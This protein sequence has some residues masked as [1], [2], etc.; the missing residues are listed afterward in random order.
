M[1]GKSLEELIS[2]LEHD[3][4][5][6]PSA[7]E[8]LDSC[9][10]VT[11][12]LDRA[13][14]PGTRREQLLDSNSS[15]SCDL[16]S[17]AEKLKRTMAPMAALVR[18]CQAILNRVQTE[19]PP[20]KEKHRVEHRDEDEA[21]PSSDRFAHGVKDKLSNLATS[22][23]RDAAPLLRAVLELSNAV[24]D[25]IKAYIV[26]PPAS[27]VW[28]E[29]EVAM[30]RRQVLLSMNVDA[31]SSASRLLP[32]VSDN[33]RSICNVL[34]PSRLQ[35][36]PELF[37]APADIDKVMT[38]FGDVSMDTNE[39]MK[40]AVKSA[41]EAAAHAAA[42][43]LDRLKPTLYQEDAI[44]VPWPT[45]G[46]YRRDSAE[47]EEAVRRFDCVRLASGSDWKDE[48][49]RQAFVDD[50]QML[51][52]TEQATKIGNMIK[53]EPQLTL[54]FGESGAGK[55]MAVVAAARCLTTQGGPRRYPVVWRA[56]V[57]DIAGTKDDAAQDLEME[58]SQY[59]NTDAK[60]A[61]EHRV[62]TLVKA[63]LDKN[64][65]KKTGLHNDG[66][67]LVLF[68]DE[69]GAYPNFVRA[70]VA[71]V[72][73]GLLNEQDGRPKHTSLG[74]FGDQTQNVEVR[75]VVAGTGVEGPTLR[76]GSSIDRYTLVSMP[77][78]VIVRVDAPVKE[79]GAAS[80]TPVPTKR[81]EILLELF[82]DEKDRDFWTHIFD[83]ATPST[84]K[85]PEEWEAHH[86][87][88]NPRA[89]VQ[90][91]L[92]Y[93]QW[94][95]RVPLESHAPTGFALRA[96]TTMAAIQFKKLNGLKNLLLPQYTWAM[97]SALSLAHDSPVARKTIE[98][99]PALQTCV[100]ELTRK[101]GILVQ[102]A[103]ERRTGPESGVKTIK[104]TVSYAQ[105][106]L[107]RA[108]AGYELHP[109][110]GEGHE[111]LLA[112]W[113][114]VQVGVCAA[115]PSFADE[116]DA[117]K[118]M[119]TKL[120]WHEGL[121]ALRE[122]MR[123]HLRPPP[124]PSGAHDTQ[125]LPATARLVFLTAASR[126]APPALNEEGIRV[127]LKELTCRNVLLNDG[128]ADAALASDALFAAV[129]AQ[130]GS[131]GEQCAST[132]NA[133]VEAAGVKQV[134][135]SQPRG[136]AAVVAVNAP[137]A[138]FADIVVVGR[139]PTA[140]CEPVIYLVQVKRYAS[141][142]LSESDV[143]DEWRKMGSS[144]ILGPT[145][146]PSSVRKFEVLKDDTTPQGAKERAAI[147]RALAPAWKHAAAKAFTQLLAAKVGAVCGAPD[148]KV[149]R[150]L[151]L[152]SQKDAPA[153]S[154]LGEDNVFIHTN[155]SSCDPESM[156][157]PLQAV[158]LDA[159]LGMSRELS[160]EV[161]A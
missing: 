87:M 134:L 56:L 118:G 115:F 110:T 94:K 112:D 54:L 71:L 13:T 57:S 117:R 116:L 97:M 47:F 19:L 60:G 124:P 16:R 130:A 51:V 126:L 86:M 52:T 109:P 148:V 5:G 31:V 72:P 120:G 2:A 30:M 74:R 45:P 68:I 91:K 84:P 62:D 44:L 55:T 39:N 67:L 21:E 101:F 100:N 43:A 90:L 10:G 25:A 29:H 8:I 159:A 3:C 138:P 22:R 161:P 6:I 38:F 156:F 14:D 26:P 11:A 93:D 113:L 53:S 92:A 158:G 133:F 103:G 155:S 151:V 105:L 123:G 131:V 157:W 152:D 42:V 63:F 12:A 35:A 27:F 107:Y 20:P 59:Y 149:F 147:K 33:V 119:T 69:A 46:D 23:G 99:D 66:L 58:L 95:D 129:S 64:V 137:Q 89:L 79:V 122:H 125:Q 83:P 34:I 77:S 36:C 73:N 153:L 7:E 48:A 98:D 24:V 160:S 127:L 82:K 65:Y 40:K 9:G 50:Q 102:H 135:A 136:V 37:A 121:G 61:A 150:V 144:A 1:A 145:Y 49:I 41:V 142:P 111:A 114:T 28:P 76:P 88:S 81:S 70:L 128:E 146:E 139:G 108:V 15:E 106:A 80:S 104:F 96:I 18:T 32:A 78:G 143:K 132:V 17:S 4:Q 141:T 154:L 85:T 140:A 75:V